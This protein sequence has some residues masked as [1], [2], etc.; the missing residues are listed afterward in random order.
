MCHCFESVEELSAEDREDIRETHSQEELRDDHT[1]EEL[2]QL[3]LA[4]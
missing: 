3:G 2:E 4:A 1:E